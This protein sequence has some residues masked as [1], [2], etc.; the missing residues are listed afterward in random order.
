[1]KD[2]KIKEALKRTALKAA[3]TA[4]K[5]GASTEEILRSA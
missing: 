3:I 2:P 5:N 4:T 1:M